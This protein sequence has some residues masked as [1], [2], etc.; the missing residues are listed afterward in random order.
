MNDTLEEGKKRVICLYRVSTTQQV[1]KSQDNDRA[2][3]DIPMQKIVCRDFADKMDW[4]IVDE[5][6]EKG[7]H[8]RSR[9]I[10]MDKLRRR[11]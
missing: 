4:I 9:C 1:Y 6:Y 3:D 8:Q 11:A 5:M 7:S 10:R 2:K